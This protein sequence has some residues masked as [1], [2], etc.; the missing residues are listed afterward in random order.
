MYYFK[1]KEGKEDKLLGKIDLRKVV[2]VQAT[3]TV[4]Y[5]VYKQTNIERAFAQQSLT[6]FLVHTCLA[7]CVGCALGLRCKGPLW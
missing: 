4:L 1:R 5:T 2:Q 7:N 6:C 3:G